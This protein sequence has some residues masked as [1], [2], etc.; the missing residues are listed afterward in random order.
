ML[1]PCCL[2]LLNHGIGGP[3]LTDAALRNLKPKDKP[4]MVTDRDG[5]YAYV[6]KSGVISFHRSSGCGRWGAHR[7]VFTSRLPAHGVDGPPR[8]RLCIRLDR[9]VFGARAAWCKGGV[10]QGGVCEAATRH[11]A[12]LGKLVPHVDRPARIAVP[13]AAE[14]DDRA[15]AAPYRHACHW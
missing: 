4:Y 12:G 8:G 11:D 7:S 10:Q 14:I 1:V 3:M 6:L 15:G 9:E 5:M 2:S 13:S